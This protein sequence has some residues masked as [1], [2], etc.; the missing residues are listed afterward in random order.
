M[1]LELD[2]S[3]YKMWSIDRKSYGK[4]FEDISSNF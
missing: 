4:S 2:L 3:G 1:S